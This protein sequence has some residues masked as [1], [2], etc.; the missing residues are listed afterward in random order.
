MEMPYACIATPSDHNFFIIE[1]VARSLTK[2]STSIAK[3]AMCLR[4]GGGLALWYSY[5]NIIQLRFH[6]L[7]NMAG[8][9]RSGHNYFHRYKG[10]FLQYNAQFSRR[11]SCFLCSFHLII[12]PCFTTSFF[13]SSDLAWDHISGCSISESVIMSPFAKLALWP[14]HTDCAPLASSAR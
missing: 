11:L 10:I 9:F 3:R 7:M 12:A 5:P 14:S 13:S 4:L 6:G 8:F 2:R 1:G